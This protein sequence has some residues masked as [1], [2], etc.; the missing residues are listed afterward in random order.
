M[1][2][3]ADEQVFSDIYDR[4]WECLFRYVIRTLP[5]EDDAADVLQELCGSIGQ[6][7]W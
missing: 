5:D 2:A 6:S 3:S 1:N 4:Y 7:L